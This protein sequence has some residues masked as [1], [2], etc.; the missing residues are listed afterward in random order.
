MIK[1]NKKIC[2]EYI[3]QLKSPLEEQMGSNGQKPNI[4]DRLRQVISKPPV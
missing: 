3:T 1:W 4:I 2:L